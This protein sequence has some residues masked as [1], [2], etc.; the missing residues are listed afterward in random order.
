MHPAKIAAF[1][2]L[3]I[4]SS[5]SAEQIVFLNFGTVGDAVEKDDQ[6]ICNEDGGTLLTLKKGARVGFRPTDLGFPNNDNRAAC[7]ASIVAM[8]E[9]DY[10]DLNIDFVTEQPKEG[11]FTTINVVTGG[12]PDW[13]MTIGGTEYHYD[14]SMNRIQIGDTNTFIDLETKKLVNQA[15]MPINGP[16]GM[17]ICLD[18]LDFPSGENILGIAQEIDE[19]NMNANKGAWVFVGAHDEGTPERNKIQLAHTMSHELGHLLGLEHD[20]GIK[21]SIMG[22]LNL[23]NYGMDKDFTD[24]LSDTGMG[25]PAATDARRK[26]EGTLPEKVNSEP[27]TRTSK[28]GDRDSHGTGEEQ[29]PTGDPV[30]DAT[31]QAKKLRSTMQPHIL[32]RGRWLYIDPIDITP[33]P[34]DPPFTDTFL[35]NGSPAFFDLPLPEPGLLP[36]LL[37]AWIEMQI[38]GLADI[39][40]VND[41]KVF[42]EGIELE[43]AFDGVDQPL[44]LPPFP[45]P[46]IVSQRLTLFLPDYL[47]L[48]QLDAILA[49]GVVQIDIFVG[50]VTPGISIDNVKLT[51][52]D[53]FTPSDLPCPGDCDGNGIVDFNDLV[54]MLFNFGPGTSPECDPDGSGTVDFNDLVTTLFLFGP[55]E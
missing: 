18:E 54:T 29:P 41:T 26:L 53:N 44:L 47:D 40:P 35:P 55:C 22:E 8:I 31:N 12:F 15:G 50:G 30:E 27:R 17:P 33:T 46:A 1:L 10:A 52:T 43:G 7:I 23:S 34:S 20:D 36:D 3:A 14:V 48:P 16:D 19:G 24:G 42:I 51:V 13:N 6:D 49:D 38:A 11:V 45:G 39:D 4:V 2:S 5:A 25:D 28:A 37:D 9:E 32:P 21:G